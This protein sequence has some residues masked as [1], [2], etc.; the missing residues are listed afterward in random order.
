MPRHQRD[1]YPPAPESRSP[2]DLPLNHQRP[3]PEYERGGGGAMVFV[4][5]ALIV[6]LLV[7]LGG[8]A[9]WFLA[10]RGG[11]AAGLG[12]EASG[13]DRSPSAPPPALATRASNTPLPGAIVLDLAAIKAV[14]GNT[15][16]AGNGPDGGRTAV[17]ASTQQSP[18]A[19]G[20]TGG[21]YFAID[22]ATSQALSGHVVSIRVTAR[23]PQASPSSRFAIAFSG[24]GLGDSGW[25]TFVPTADFKTYD[26]RVGLPAAVGPTDYVGIWADV[27]GLGKALEVS[28][29]EI[30]PLS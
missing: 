9:Y 1:P 13:V 10:H 17:I 21:A 11:A 7:L 22:P 4:L 16:T 2:Y 15:V 14:P 24:N 20:T 3:V 27:Y 19:S 8:G 18:R 29:V 26:L 6:V 12:G 5:V 25:I 28:K 30:V 23:A